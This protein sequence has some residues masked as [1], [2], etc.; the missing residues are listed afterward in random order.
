VGGGVGAVTVSTGAA[1][2]VSL[3]FGVNLVYLIAV[4]AASPH[5]VQRPPRNP[6]GA[7]K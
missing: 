6:A 1:G 2:A 7:G 4:E 3:A 5:W